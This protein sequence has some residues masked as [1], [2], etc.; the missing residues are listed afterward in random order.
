MEG[1]MKYQIELYFG[2]YS[3]KRETLMH[4]AGGGGGV[5]KFWCKN[6]L[7]IGLL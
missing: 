6:L 4:N 5:R 2:C 3:S 1:V 7:A